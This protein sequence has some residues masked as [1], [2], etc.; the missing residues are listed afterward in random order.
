MTKTICVYC[1]ANAG[2]NPVYAE[3]ARALGRALVDQNLAL[4]TAA[5]MSD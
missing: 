5:A 3:A 1:G 2:D 4:C